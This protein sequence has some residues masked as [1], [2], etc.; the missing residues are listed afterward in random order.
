M[1]G[2]S[3]WRGWEGMAAGEPFLMGDWSDWW[4]LSDLLDGGGCPFGLVGLFVILQC[5]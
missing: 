2:D 4:D 3:A 1:Q 5:N